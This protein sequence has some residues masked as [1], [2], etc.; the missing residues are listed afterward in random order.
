MFWKE[1][2][3]AALCICVPVLWGLA[4]YRISSLIEKRVLRHRRS[5]Q[6]SESEKPSL[7]LDYHI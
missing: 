1:A 6:E 5:P 2:G 3:Y 7:P 4:V